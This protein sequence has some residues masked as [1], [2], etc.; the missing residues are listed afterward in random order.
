MITI[1]DYGMGN[2]GSIKNMFKRIGVPAVVSSDLETI[3][4]ASKLLLPGVGAFDKAMARINNSE[5]R[6]LLDRKA[7]EERVPVLGICLGMQLLTC[8]SEEGDS[9]GLGW[10][11]AKATRFP[12]MPDLK[13]PHMG[14]NVVTPTRESSLTK[15]LPEDSRFYF[16]HSYCVHVDNEEDS[17]LKTDYGR[18]F[19]SAIQHDNIYGCQFHPEKSHKFGMKLLENFAS[20]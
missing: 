11:A 18:R 2:L 5:L 17:L 3:S 7:L 16:V 10:I 8:A 14:W 1:V 4:S 19:D 20:L 6:Q 13:V 9:A 12:I 15:G